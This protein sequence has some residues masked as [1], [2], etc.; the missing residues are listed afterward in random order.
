MASRRN[1]YSRSKADDLAILLFAGLVIYGWMNIFASVFESRMFQEILGDS[2]N[3]AQGLTY[4]QFFQVLTHSIT[5]FSLSSSKQLIWMVT[6]FILIIIITNVD[7]RTYETFSYLFY[8]VVILLLIFV[9]LFAREI[10]GARSWIEIGG[11]RLQ[12]SEFAKFATALAL[13]KYLTT[14]QKRLRRLLRRVIAGFIIFLPAALIV[15]QGDAGSALVFSAFALVLYRENLIPGWVLIG[16]ILMAT[17]FVLT[18]SFKETDLIVR[19]LIVPVA[20]ATLIALILLRRKSYLGNLMILGVGGMIGLFIFSV[21]YIFTEVLEPHQKDRIM[22]LIDPDVDPQGRGIRWN[23]KQSLIAIGSGGLWGKGYLQGTQTELGYVPE[24]STDFIFCTVGEEH[25]WMGSLV[26]I[27]LYMFL[28]YRLLLMAERQ[29]DKFARVYGY[30]VASILFFHFTVNIGMTIGLFPVI[31]IPL[32]LI[33]YGGS[34][35]WSFTILFFI[36]IKLD[37]SREKQMQRG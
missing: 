23:M 6:A 33:S 12:P 5:D 2:Y 11:F 31:G 32:P 8:A 4:Y 24:Q 1:V 16:G 18:L 7:Y 13:A 3:P 17:L 15:L 21:D 26:V 34:S 29:R 36:F 19:Y 28:L 10:K 22:V 9:M 30:S 37:A 35:L 25:G 20:A 27:S 14:P